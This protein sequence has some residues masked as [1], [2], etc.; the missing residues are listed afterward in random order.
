MRLA[1]EADLVSKDTSVFDYGCGRG[2]DIKFLR[3][4]GVPAE[5]WDPVHRPSVSRQEA[6]V[7]NLGFV[8]NVVEDVKERE[9]ILCNAWELAEHILVIAARL[10]HD[11]GDGFE[12]LGDG[13]ISTRETFQKFFTQDELRDWI[14]GTIGAPAL[15]AAP[16]VFFVFRDKDKEQQYIAAKY[17]R[18]RAAPKVRKSDLLFDE[19]ENLLSPLMAFLSERGRLPEPWELQKAEELT[20]VFGSIRRAFAVIRRVTGPGQWQEFRR[21]RGDELLLQFALD[22]FAGRPRMSELPKDIQIDVR[23]F[24]SSYKKA[25]AFA[26][27]LLFSAGDMNNIETEIRAAQHGKLT[28]S[29]LYTHVEAL[30]ELSPVL[31][32]YEGCA[33]AFAG[34]VDGANIV[35][36][37]RRKPQISY[38]AYPT[39]D[40]E[41]HP[42][43][44]RSTKVALQERDIRGRLYA[45][46]SNPPILHRKEEFISID[47]PKR[48]KFSKLTKQ[49]ER[50]GLFEDTSRIGTRLGW[51][52]VLSENGVR[53]RGH[54]VV[55]M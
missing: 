19:H 30:H 29:A 14:S 38:L 49:E 13:H 36:L 46:M 23:D 11:A 18:R 50:Y 12:P 31:R 33:K 51:E 25:C 1:L 10:I 53:L 41:P 32:V 42:A 45:E 22:R 52:E 21:E 40:K 8:V 28:G 39:F 44:W 4:L 43:L 6:S 37:H 9:E 54:R 27:N 35:K 48:E 55:R 3:E 24:F 7:V 26:D 16:G 47:D 15:A 2:D 5:G 20:A 17:R 34:E